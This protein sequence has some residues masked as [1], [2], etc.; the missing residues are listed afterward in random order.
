MIRG[1]KRENIE[2]VYRVGRGEAAQ[3]DFLVYIRVYPFRSSFFSFV[4]FVY[5]ND[6][7]L[8]AC[9]CASHSR[10]CMHCG[11]IN[12]SLL[13]LPKFKQVHEFDFDFCKGA[14]RLRRVFGDAYFVH[15]SD[16]FLIEF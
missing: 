11:K 5:S 12:S 10:P 7:S 3:K 16:A 1:K 4:L 8:L 15:L 6:F 13:V 14:E 2:Q 9:F